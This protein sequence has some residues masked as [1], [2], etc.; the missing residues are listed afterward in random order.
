MQNVGDIPLTIDI[1]AVTANQAAE[2]VCREHATQ[3]GLSTVGDLDRCIP[4]ISKYIQNAF[5]TV[6][7]PPITVSYYYCLIDVFYCA[8]TDVNECEQ[9]W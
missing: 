9:C 1:N 4:P 7:S 2:Y 3:F 8:V 5:Q 6:S